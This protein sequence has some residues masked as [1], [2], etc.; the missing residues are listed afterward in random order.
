M[1]LL[2]RPRPFFQNKVNAG[3]RAQ[4]RRLLYSYSDPTGHTQFNNV[5]FVVSKY[6]TRKCCPGVEC[7]DSV[8]IYSRINRYLFLFSKHKMNEMGLKERGN[9]VPVE[10]SFPSRM[11]YCRRRCRSLR[12]SAFILL[13]HM[14]FTYSR[15]NRM[16]TL[17]HCRIIKPNFAQS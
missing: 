16:P 12:A 17:S 11:K 1:S 9:F 13:D 4:I 6:G 3:I 15:N 14:Q 8:N 5:T 7:L 2:T 10:T